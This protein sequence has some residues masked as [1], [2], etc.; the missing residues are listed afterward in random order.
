MATFQDASFVPEG[1]GYIIPNFSSL[2]LMD[3]DLSLKIALIRMDEKRNNKI[4]E[5]KAEQN[6]SVLAKIKADIDGTVRKMADDR[7]VL[8]GQT[9]AG[10]IDSKGNYDRDSA[11][12]LLESYHADDTVSNNYA[13]KFLSSSEDYNNVNKV[14]NAITALSNFAKAKKDPIYKEKTISELETKLAGTIPGSEL[15]NP[16]MTVDEATGA[17]KIDQES[18]MRDKSLLDALKASQKKPEG[19]SV[20]VQNMPATSYAKEIE[21]ADALSAQL[22]AE[23]DIQ[24]AIKSFGSGAGNFAEYQVKL[25]NVLEGLGMSQEAKMVK[26]ANNIAALQTV[27]DTSVLSNVKAM[28]G[29]QLSNMETARVE[30]LY[31]KI[32]D[33]AG[34]LALASRVRSAGISRKMLQ[35]ELAF[36]NIVGAEKGKVNPYAASK[37]AMNTL[38]I[39]SI[40][41]DKAGNPIFF[42]EFLEKYQTDYDQRGLG[43]KERFDEWRNFAKEWEDK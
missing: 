25:G 18:I 38:N 20:T 16:Y 43:Y 23:R 30:K 15:P 14:K 42:N 13:P 31:G 12:A 35:K 6:K 37:A 40:A 3:S 17:E 24:N 4:L 11:K 10:L 39:P 34:K 7:T 36:S 22:N 9:A 21:E 29:G 2:P 8:F 26:G 1:K 41:I 33:N 32:T 5:M 28:L 27:L 19:T